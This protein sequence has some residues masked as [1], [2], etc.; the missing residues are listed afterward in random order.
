MSENEFGN[1]ESQVSCQSQTDSLIL[2]DGIARWRAST[3]E[4]RHLAFFKTVKRA[5]FFLAFD[6]KLCYI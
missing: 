2:L 4:T 3:P 5:K 1:A 6:L